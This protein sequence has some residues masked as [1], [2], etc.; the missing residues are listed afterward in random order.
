MT[1]TKL[2]ILKWFFSFFSSISNRPYFG[3]FSHV[4]PE[5]KQNKHAA[6]LLL[7]HCKNGANNFENW[8]LL[9]NS[10]LLSVAGINNSKAVDD[11]CTKLTKQTENSL[12]RNSNLEAVIKKCVWLFPIYAAHWGPQQQQQQKLWLST[13]DQIPLS[14]LKSRIQAISTLSWG[15]Q[16]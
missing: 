10:W 11:C 4:L 8:A 13:R 5:S 6:L 1:F 16:E 12:E 2:Q 15:Y 3:A 7:T 14:G 9:T